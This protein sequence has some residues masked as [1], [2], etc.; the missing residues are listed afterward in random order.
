MHRPPFWVFIRAL[1]F[2]LRST[3]C[4]IVRVYKRGFDIRNASTKSL[5][6]QARRQKLFDGYGPTSDKDKFLRACAK[7]MGNLLTSVSWM[8]HGPDSSD[9]DEVLLSREALG[10]NQGPAKRSGGSRPAKRQ[11]A[12]QISSSQP[13]IM[14]DVRTPERKVGFNFHF[15]LNVS[16][17]FISL[18]TLY[19]AAVSNPNVHNDRQRLSEYLKSWTVYRQMFKSFSFP[20]QPFIVQP[21]QT[22]MFTAITKG[23]P[24]V[25]NLALFIAKYLANFC[26]NRFH[27][28]GNPLERVVRRLVLWREV[29]RQ[30]QGL[31]IC[32]LQMAGIL[33]K[34]LAEE[35]WSQRILSLQETLQHDKYRWMLAPRDEG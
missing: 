1:L 8:E 27:F 13:D 18:A 29:R 14:T 6:N 5:Y 12:K 33:Q 10:K 15:N 31:W 28:P 24:S 11:P 23:F 16:A 34:L 3:D 22:L 2:Q 17:K 19:W 7:T 25:W 30:V 9:E 4:D 35:D 26:L 32:D 20:W 21:F